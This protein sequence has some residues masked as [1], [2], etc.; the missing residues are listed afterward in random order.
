MDW[1]AAI[2]GIEDLETAEDFFDFF[3][4]SYESSVVRS[5]HLH[6]MHYFHQQIE[7]LTDTAATASMA[8]RFSL[9]RHVLQQS[10]QA[11]LDETVQQQSTLRVFVKQRPSFVPLTDLQ[12]VRW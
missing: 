7:Q 1:F 10:Y 9:A 6:L 2:P 5:K 4:V 8:A 3:R 11:F 12:G